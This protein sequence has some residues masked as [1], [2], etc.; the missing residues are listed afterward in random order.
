MDAQREQ[1]RDREREGLRR[2]HHAGPPEELIVVGETA[3]APGI[4]RTHIRQ[5]GGEEIRVKI[6][7]RTAR[8]GLPVEHRRGAG[9]EIPGSLDL[10]DLVVAVVPAEVS[11]PGTRDGAWLAGGRA[12]GH[13]GDDD[14]LPV[15]LGIMEGQDHG[16]HQ[17]L[18]G[19]AS[20]TRLESLG[21]VQAYGAKAGH[22]VEPEDEPATSREIREGTQ[23]R[24]Q[25]LGQPSL[26]RLDLDRDRVGPGRPQRDDE[27]A[28]VEHRESIHPQAR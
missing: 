12:L 28:D 27:V 17:P 8:H 16:R 13:F 14:A 21:V 3:K 1:A 18:S 6:S 9:G 11:L 5:P 19:E 22:L 24:R 10:G 7:L 2:R 20:E 4:P 23:G 25:R 26:C 15:N